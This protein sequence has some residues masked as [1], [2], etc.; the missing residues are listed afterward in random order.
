MLHIYSCMVK[1]FGLGEQI[2]KIEW[3]FLPGAIAP[4]ST[5]VTVQEAVTTFTNS[6]PVLFLGAHWIPLPLTREKMQVSGQ[7]PLQN[8][9]AATSSCSHGLNF[10]NR[11]KDLFNPNSHILDHCPP[12]H[13][14]S[15]QLAI[16]S[17]NLFW[18]SQSTN[19]KVRKSSVD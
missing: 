16:H 17:T 9:S 18:N 3:P 12:T 8:R 13:T 2:L 15:V 5:Q 19:L 4:S 14:G 11:T 1:C 6:S 10:T 7:S